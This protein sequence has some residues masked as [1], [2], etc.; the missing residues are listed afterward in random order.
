MA[1]SAAAAGRTRNLAVLLE[2]AEA[3]AVA[4]RDALGLRAVAEGLGDRIWFAFGDRLMSYGPLPDA[5][6]PP[7]R[8]S[9][10]RFGFVNHR[11]KSAR[12]GVR[13]LQV[14]ATGRIWFQTNAGIFW[15]DGGG[16]RRLGGRDYGSR[17]AW[18]DAPDDRWFGV[19]RGTEFDER[20]GQWGVYRVH[21]AYATFLAL[22]VEQTAEPE[23]DFALVG[24]P[25][26]TR[27]GTLW[28]GTRAAAFGFD[29]KNFDI[30]DRRRLRRVG[31]SRGVDLRGCYLDSRD[32]LWLADRGAGVFVYDGERVVD[33]TVHHG[34]AGND[35]DPSLR[36]PLAIAEDA[37]G[38]LWFGTAGSGVWRYE[39]SAEDPV[40]KGRF[41]NFGRSAGLTRAATPMI[42]RTRAGGLLFGRHRST[43]IDRF[44]AGR[45]EPFR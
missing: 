26:R 35:D 29:G 20:E 33:F 22:P 25:L 23:G 40:G 24:G 13:G 45:F 12:T 1:T 21:D 39:P 30:L 43:R 38:N 4:R 16:C 7:L 14:D 34:M 41:T 32:R 31:D 6:P 15:S 36:R 8:R 44:R 37:T 10:V 19:D 17:N 28:L 2:E 42:Y 5:V 27:A 3:D 9:E 18:S 11:V